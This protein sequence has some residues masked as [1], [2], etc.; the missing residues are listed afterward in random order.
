MEREYDGVEPVEW[1]NPDDNPFAVCGGD[2]PDDYWDTP[3]YSLEPE[4][5]PDVVVER[6]FPE[7]VDADLLDPEYRRVY[8]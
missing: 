3:D 2:L 7:S 5:K 4:S 1:V 8:G 6:A